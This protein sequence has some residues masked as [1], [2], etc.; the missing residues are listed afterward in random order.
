MEKKG[1]RNSEREKKNGKKRKEKLFQRVRDLFIG[2]FSSK[3]L[4]YTS[5]L[6]NKVRFSLYANLFCVHFLMFK[7]DILCAIM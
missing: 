5:N 4:K 3:Q 7:L 6:T 1:E 2:I